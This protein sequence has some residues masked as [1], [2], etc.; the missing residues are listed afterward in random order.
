MV[1][2]NKKQNA[3][4]ENISKEDPEETSPDILMIYPPRFL[5]QFQRKKEVGLLD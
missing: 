3:N 2:D 4:Q 1:E 5:K